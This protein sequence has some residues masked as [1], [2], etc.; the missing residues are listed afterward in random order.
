MNYTIAVVDEGLLSLTTF[1]T[2]APFSYF[3]AREALGVKTGFL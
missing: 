3:Y 1:R 2:P